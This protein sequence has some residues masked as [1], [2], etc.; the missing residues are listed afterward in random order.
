MISTDMKEYMKIF[1]A[2]IT[3]VICLIIIGLAIKGLIIVIIIVIIVLGIIFL[4]LKAKK[5]LSKN[6]SNNWNLFYKKFEGFS[7]DNFR[8]VKDEYRSDSEDEDK[9]E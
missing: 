9:I 3:A 1:G 6:N 2:F 4:F 5:W 8:L 7:L